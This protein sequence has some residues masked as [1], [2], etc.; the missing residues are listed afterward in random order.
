[1]R[2]EVTVADTTSRSVDPD[3]G[4][5]DA[6]LGRK[7][8][9]KEGETSEQKTVQPPLA[10]APFFPRDYSPRWHVFLT[11]SKQGKMSVPPFTFTSFDKPIYDASGKPTFNIQTLKA[12]FQA[13][14]QAGQYTFVMHLV[15]YVFC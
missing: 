9:I 7:K 4:D 3:E 5:L 2:F 1:M 15:W 14:P 12:Q 6:I 11:D 8:P 13:P 10:Y